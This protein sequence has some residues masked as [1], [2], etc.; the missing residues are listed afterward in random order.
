MRALGGYPQGDLAQAP[1]VA[2][3]NGTRLHGVGHQSRLDNAQVQDAVGLGERPVGIAGGAGTVDAQVGAHVLV[4]QRRPRL[5]G[6][7]EVDHRR[8]RLV[9]HL[10]QFQCVAG[11]VGVLGHH[12]GHRLTLVLGDFGRHGKA[13][14]GLHVLQD[15]GQGQLRDTGGIEFGAGHHGDHARQAPRGGHVHAADACVGMGTAEHQHHRRVGGHDVAGVAALSLD[16]SEVFLAPYGRS[17]QPFV[18]SIF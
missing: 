15:S 12:N 14:D 13:A 6:A 17:N 5:Q 4:D 8:Q 2:G 7:L 3:G 16:Q 10:D 11:N 1:L 9:V 18:F